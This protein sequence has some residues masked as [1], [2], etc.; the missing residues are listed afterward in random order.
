MLDL[1][2]LSY[3]IILL[4]WRITHLSPRA[5]PQ[6]FK[7]TKNTTEMARFGLPIF[8]LGNEVNS[9]LRIIKY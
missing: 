1:S 8:F 3:P 7:A 4:G 6:S 9:P 5:P 2:N